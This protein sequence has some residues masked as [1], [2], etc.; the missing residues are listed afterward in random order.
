MQKR[1]YKNITEKINAASDR[2]RR[3][4]ERLRIRPKRETE[5]PIK[6][7]KNIFVKR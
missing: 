2:L 1:N 4:T 6:F 7:D 5:A 3:E